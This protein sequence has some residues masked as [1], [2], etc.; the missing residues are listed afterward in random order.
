MLFV[1]APIL[2][3]ALLSSGLLPAWVASNV[4]WLTVF[5]IVSPGDL[6]YYSPILHFVALLLIGVPLARRESRRT[7]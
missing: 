7:P 6:Y 5:P 3:G 2:G 4:G 1:A